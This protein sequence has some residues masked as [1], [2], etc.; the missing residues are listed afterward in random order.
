MWWPAHV[1]LAIAMCNAVLACIP[2]LARAVFVPATI[3]NADTIEYAVGPATLQAAVHVQ[4]P[5]TARAFVA[6]DLLRP[7][8]PRGV[9]VFNTRVHHLNIMCAVLAAVFAYLAAHQ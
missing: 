5:E 9:A 7:G 6:L 4:Q 8:A 1:L 3:V 2:L